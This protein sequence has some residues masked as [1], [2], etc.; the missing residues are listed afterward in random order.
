MNIN[1]PNTEFSLPNTTTA[2]VT[3]AYSQQGTIAPANATPAVPT[4]VIPQHLKIHLHLLI[5]PPQ[6]V[7]QVVMTSNSIQMQRHM[8]N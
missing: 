1:D 8:I 2:D 7:T 4:P 6:T 5:L 3:D